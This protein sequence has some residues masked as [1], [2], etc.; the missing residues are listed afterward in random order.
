MDRLVG[1]RVREERR[2][3]GL[4]QAD[5]GNLIGVS[6]QQAQKYEQGANRLS[7]STLAKIADALND[8]LVRLFADVQDRR[9]TAAD[10]TDAR[11]LL[12]CFSGMT[13]PRRALLVAIAEELRHEPSGRGVGQPA[14]ALSSASR[15]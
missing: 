6:P 5:L 4:T 1:Q 15:S 10:R 9:R 2:A 8:S 13:P 11:R 7:A 3:A 14:G 12:D